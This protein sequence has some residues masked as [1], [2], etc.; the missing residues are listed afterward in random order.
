MSTVI[1]M[2]KENSAGHIIAQSN[3][4]LLKATINATA[5]TLKKDPQEV[6]VGFE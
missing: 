3:D 6:I 5:A 1:I 4:D 2:Y